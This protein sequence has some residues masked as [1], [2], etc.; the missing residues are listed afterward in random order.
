[1]DQQAIRESYFNSW[2]KLEYEH[3]EKV[4]KVRT[5]FAND[6]KTRDLLL[7]REDERYA[8]A[9]EEWMRY[10]D[11]RV[12]EEVKANQEIIVS[13]QLAFEA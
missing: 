11:N 13:R 12:K 4:Q 3:N 10:E 8:K 7:Q 1:E 9:I 2:E 6:P 5:N